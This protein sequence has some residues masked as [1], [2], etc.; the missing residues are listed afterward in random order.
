[1]DS[2]LGSENGVPAPNCPVCGREG[3]Y[4]ESLARPGPVSF[5]SHVEH[6]FLSRVSCA[7]C[8]IQFGTFRPWRNLTSKLRR[9][10]REAR[11]SAT[12]ENILGDDKFLPSL[13]P[14]RRVREERSSTVSNSPAS[15]HFLVQS[16]RLGIH[17]EIQFSM[18]P[19]VKECLRLVRSLVDIP[20]IPEIARFRDTPT[21]RISCRPLS[22]DSRI[23]GLVSEIE[24]A[25]T[26]E[27]WRG[28]SPG[29]VPPASEER[30]VKE[31]HEH[32]THQD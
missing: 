18:E 12:Y 4:C 14:H 24:K 7:G 31:M 11:S 30:V 5:V 23:T 21:S 26:H 16:R 20:R 9:I 29:V 22:E 3:V 27:Y 32:S 15:F 19:L 6:L 8:G 17:F 13:N 2:K 25:Q 10:P 28:N 1:M